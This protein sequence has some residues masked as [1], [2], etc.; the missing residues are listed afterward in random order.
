MLNKKTK[1]KKTD[2]TRD[3]F[4]LHGNM[5]LQ[6]YDWKT[7]VFYVEWKKHSLHTSPSELSNLQVTTMIAI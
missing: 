3:N 7:H 6:N 2:D 4:G 5:N 1:C